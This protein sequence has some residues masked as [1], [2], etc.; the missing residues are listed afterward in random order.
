MASR[1]T[2]KDD[3]FL[4]AYFDAVGDYVGTHDLGRPVGAAKRRAE[5]LKRSGAWAAL[6]RAEAAEI[7]FRKLAGHPV[8]EG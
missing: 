7:E 8:V 2:V 3:K 1:W 4:H 6:D 5:F